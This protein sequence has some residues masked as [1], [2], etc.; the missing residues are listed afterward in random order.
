MLNFLFRFNGWFL[1][2]SVLLIAGLSF[3]STRI[4]IENDLE[5]FYKD[6]DPSRLAHAKLTAQYPEFDSLIVLLE[7]PRTFT[8]NPQQI[9][10][11]F[12]L[13]ARLKA[14]PYA[15][16]VASVQSILVPVPQSSSL[17]LVQPLKHFDALT[18]TERQHAWR[19]VMSQPGVEGILVSYDQ[20]MAA[21]LVQMTL[22]GPRDSAAKEVQQA[23]STIKSE[24]LLQYPDS[25]VYVTGSVALHYGALDAF[26]RD[27][28]WLAPVILLF[29]AIILWFMSRS[30]AA[31]VAGNVVVGAIL[32]TAGLSGIW[33]VVF[34]QTSIL[35]FALVFIIGL[36]DSIHVITQFLLRLS[37]GSDKYQAMTESIRFNAGP[38]VLTSVTTAMGFL[39]LNFVDSPPFAV[40]GNVT[41]VG[42]MLALLFSFVA[43]P[44]MLMLLPVRAH[45]LHQ[46]LPRLSYWVAEQATRFPRLVLLVLGV[47]TLLAGL[48]LQSNQI[49]ND[50]LKYFEEGTETRTA[51]EAAKGRFA[52][53]HSFDVAIQN[54]NGG[55]LNDIAF[56]TEADQL[57][58]WLRQQQGINKVESYVGL[59]K[60]LNR[61]F[62]SEGLPRLPESEAIANDLLMLYQFALPRSDLLH[63]IVDVENGGI[64]ITVV[65]RPLSN[66]QLI[67]LQARIEE[68]LDS[69]PN[70]RTVAV[71]G[72]SLMVAHLGQTIIDS[73]LY[74]A[75][76]ALVT[77]TIMIVIGLRSFYYGLVS[78]IPNIIPA[79]VVY[80]IWGW[81]RGEIDVAAS[82]AFC[83][84]LGIIVDDTIHIMT[85]YKTARGS[86]LEQQAAIIKTLGEVGPALFTTTVV[87]SVGFY[88][89][90]LSGFGPNAT[91][92]MM[93]FMMVSLA[94]VFDF[95][96]LPAVLM[97]LD[98]R[99]TVRI[100][101]QGVVN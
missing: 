30:L 92:G 17:E 68:H 75:L 37:R 71:G 97:L 21:V 24:W 73:M 98:R 88:I 18:Y 41:A 65:T 101:G 80:G 90:S 54:A 13:Q 12:D 50:E 67:A 34:N 29:G 83:I 79:L 95:I 66:Q 20:R 22:T 100:M 63:T 56:L 55:Q 53:M 48:H 49:N 94:L 39:S 62:D 61:T 35:A 86:G 2:L 3:C 89:V 16:D 82:T 26:Q 99:I 74:G 4:H 11:L 69:L 40:L 42:V 15:V 8:E 72:R 45:A 78:L 7:W 25:N 59:L 14:L 81:W 77:I 96:L 32:S 64:K 58:E 43:L 10:A 23:M 85:H 5:S 19:Q 60:E 1:F 57:V 33:G 51:I 91:I 38:M 27:V 31:L 44:G 93:S 47:L 28:R 9:A 6:S 36:A 84:G 52:G 70:V 46:S 87:L 76:T